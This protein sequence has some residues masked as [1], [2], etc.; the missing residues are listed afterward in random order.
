MERAV[1][2]GFRGGDYR[3]RRSDPILPQGSRR[4]AVD[5]HNPLAVSTGA[6]A[7]RRGLRRLGLRNARLCARLPDQ[8]IAIA[9]RRLYAARN[10]GRNRVVATGG[11]EVMQMKQC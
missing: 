8:L 7:L 11:S 4:C 5:P 3:Q 2:G 10:A 9:D 6:C 1:R